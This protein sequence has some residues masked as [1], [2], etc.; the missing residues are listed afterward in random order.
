MIISSDHIIRQMRFDINIKGDES[1]LTLG[2]EIAEFCSSEFISLINKQFDSYPNSKQFIIDKI[3]IDLGNVVEMQWE[4]Q[5]KEKFEKTLKEELD[6][7]FFNSS[8]QSPNAIIDKHFNSSLT[9]RDNGQDSNEN[10]RKIEVDK[11]HFEAFVFYLDK[12]FF[13][14]WIDSKN[15]HL[16]RD[17]VREVLPLKRSSMLL[18]KIKSSS[19][20]RRRLVKSTTKIELINLF[21]ENRNLKAFLNFEPFLF[22]ALKLSFMP[23]IT[24]RSFETTFRELLLIHYD[25]LNKDPIETLVICIEAFISQ[26]THPVD[27]K[28]KKKEQLFEKFFIKT[29]SFLKTYS[30]SK[31]EFRAVIFQLLESK[32]EKNKHLKHKANSTNVNKPKTLSQLIRKEEANSKYVA[33]NN[34][35]KE[36]PL[37]HIEDTNSFS[38]TSQELEEGV[39]VNNAGIVLLHP[40]LVRFFENLNLYENGSFTRKNSIH[41]AI[42]LL[43]YLCTGSE[44]SLE[45]ECLLFKHLLGIPWHEVIDL[46][47]QLSE[48]EKNQAE[49]LLNSVLEHWKALK[50]S[51]SEA[52]QE[53]FIQREAK[54]W[55]DQTGWQLHIEQKA[56]DILLQQLPWGIGM[57]K[58]PW[59]KDMLIVN[60]I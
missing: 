41:K 4:F 27:L 14:W 60:W 21:D 36:E 24:L 32:V 58:L 39:Y 17:L 10:F 46:E 51:S 31:S 18:K 29:K 11:S 22:E 12:G 57:I 50:S 55:K 43:A 47:F 37:N 28:N 7:V 42:K 8:S 59:M 49:M 44:D 25:E 6:K 33:S 23:Q 3:S 2:E 20:A 26:H 5:L 40:F 30:V 9:V 38:L 48:K 19:T 45:H 1:Q 35:H 53:T 16:M 56:Q 13:P 52:L 54:L 34:E 15:I